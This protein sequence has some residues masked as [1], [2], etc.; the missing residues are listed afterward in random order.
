M[1]PINVLTVPPFN[2]ILFI[3]N[4]KLSWNEVDKSRRELCV[5][6]ESVLD[7][8]GKMLVTKDDR[9]RKE[10]NY[11]IHSSKHTQGWPERENFQ[12]ARNRRLN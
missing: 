7:K 12:P 1:F 5:R 9:W 10:M 11:R 8:S 3:T 6:S 2:P 4:N